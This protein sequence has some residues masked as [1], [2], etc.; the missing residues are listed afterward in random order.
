MNTEFMK[1]VTPQIMIVLIFLLIA[2]EVY[3]QE[4]TFQGLPWGSTREQVITRLGQPSREA[5]LSILYYDGVTVA[6]YTASLSVL[7]QVR[8]GMRRADYHFPNFQNS[9]LTL[10][11]YS[12]LRQQLIIRYGQPSRA[13]ISFFEYWSKNNFH[14]VLGMGDQEVFISYFPDTEW[15][16]FLKENNI[17]LESFGL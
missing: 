14:V 5:M 9:L 1:R 16:T 17:D 4:F 6:G 12:D 3:G 2:P 10:A 8:Q 15:E 11:A 7:V 13:R